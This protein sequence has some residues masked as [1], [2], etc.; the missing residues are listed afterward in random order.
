MP[1]LVDVDLTGLWQMLKPVTFLLKTSTDKTLHVPQFCNYQGRTDSKTFVGNV[2][3]LVVS[4]AWL[5]Q[6]L[7]PEYSHSQDDVR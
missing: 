1:T 7:F 2:C 5:V 4:I 6:T 3:F